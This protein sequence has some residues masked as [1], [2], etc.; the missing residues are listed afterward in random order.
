MNTKYIVGGVALIILIIIGITVKKEANA[1][2]ED[3]H[4]GVITALTGDFS[5]WGQATQLGIELAEK[6]LLEEGISVEFTFENAEL[7]PRKGLDAAQKLVNI[8]KVDALYSE[9]TTLVSAIASFLKDK[10]II[11]IYDAPSVTPLVESPYLFKT[12]IDYKG[13]CVAVGQNLYD[14]GIRIIGVLEVRTEFGELC[15]EGL[16]SIFGPRGY[17]NTKLVSES[18]LLGTRDFRTLLNKLNAEG[19]EAIVNGSFSSETFASIKDARDL[20]MDIPFVFSHSTVSPEL[21]AQPELLENTIVFGLPAVEPMFLNR[22]REEFPNREITDYNP[23]ALGYI[24]TMQ[25]ARALHVCNKDIECTR[26]ELSK[27]SEEP[28][29]GFKG[30]EDRIAKFD[31]LIQEWNGEGFVPI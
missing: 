16:E 5:Y 8:D 6:D 24:H 21:L 18:Y 14:R 3:I 15:L 9:Y 12:Y 23:L 25:M 10:N 22:V 28:L 11:N 19:I 30:F 26:D 4:I 27:A 1:P 17:Q 13:S 20:G 2:T 7:D 31:I 29:I